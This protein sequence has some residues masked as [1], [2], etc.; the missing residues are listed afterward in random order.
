MPTNEPDVDK[1]VKNAMLLLLKLLELTVLQAM[2][3]AVFVNA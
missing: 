2:C 3:A 1:L